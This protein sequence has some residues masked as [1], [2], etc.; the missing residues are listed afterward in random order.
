[1][2]ITELARANHVPVYRFVTLPLLILSKFSL[3]T[4]LKLKDMHFSGFVALSSV[5]IHTVHA[6]A[7]S[8]L[9]GGNWVTLLALL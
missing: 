5:C 3:Q 1:M 4:H 8:K 7:V 6:D 9:L 2:H